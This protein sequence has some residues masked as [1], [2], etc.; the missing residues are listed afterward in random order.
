MPKESKK[1]K[2]NIYLLKPASTLD[3]VLKEPSKKAHS[4]PLS[5][6]LPFTG[7]IWVQSS[8]AARPRLETLSSVRNRERVG[9]FVYP[10]FECSCWH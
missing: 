5:A 1:Q 7:K 6:G 3:D 4:F 8:N 10:E 9:I 2:L